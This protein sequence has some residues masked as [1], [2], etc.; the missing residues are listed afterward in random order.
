MDI[1]APAYRWTAVRAQLRATPGAN[2]AQVEAEVLARLY[3][4]LNP[5]TG[6]PDGKGWEFGGELFVSDV[7]QALQG[8]ANVQFIRNVTMFAAAAGGGGEGSPVESLAVV[9][10]G[11]VASGVHEVEFV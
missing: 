8:I 7:Y 1:R 6:G 9:A 5:L 3:R 10:H 2:Q 11:V 4:F